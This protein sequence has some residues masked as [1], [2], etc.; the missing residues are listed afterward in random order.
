MFIKVL[1]PGVCNMFIKVL[2]RGVYN[3]FIKVLDCG[4]YNMFIKVLECGVYN[5]FIMALTLLRSALG[6]VGSP[7]TCASGRSRGRGSPAT[8][9]PSATNS[10]CLSGSSAS[11][12]VCPTR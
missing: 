5:M 9:R 2:E 4:V 3:M 6:C 11:Q 8:S 10:L 1:D 12:Q 7:T